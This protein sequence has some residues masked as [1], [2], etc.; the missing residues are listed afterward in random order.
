MGASGVGLDLLAER[1][2]LDAQAA[3]RPDVGV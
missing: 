1:P 2:K 3:E